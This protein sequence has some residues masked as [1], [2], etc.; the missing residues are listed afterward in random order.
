M[1]SL[2]GI[3]LVI[4]FFFG[5]IWFQS[6]DRQRKSD[7]SI[8]QAIAIVESVAEYERN[9]NYF[10]RRVAEYHRRAFEVA[11]KSG[12]FKSS[13]DERSYRIVL[14]SQFM[15]DAEAVGNV[16]VSEAMRRE[17]QKLNHLP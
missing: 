4:V 9:Q 2:R 17:L 3:V 8:E 10:D 11:Y 14:L 1:K 5:I 12:R 6:L 16:E 7:D 13:F 15:N